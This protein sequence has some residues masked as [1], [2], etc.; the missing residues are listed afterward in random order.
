MDDDEFGAVGVV[1]GR[2]RRST[3]R[4]H[5]PV[6]ILQPQAPYDPVRAAAVGIGYQRTELWY[7]LRME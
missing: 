3:R 7:G 1:S 4:K 2:R 6:P 5:A